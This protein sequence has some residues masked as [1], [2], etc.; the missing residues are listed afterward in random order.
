MEHGAWQACTHA[1]ITHSCPNTQAAVADR[2]APAPV[3]HAG[4]STTRTTGQDLQTETVQT[5][6]AGSTSFYRSDCMDGLLSEPDRYTLWFGLLP[7]GPPVRSGPNN[8]ATSTSISGATRAPP[9]ATLTMSKRCGA[10][11]KHGASVMGG[12]EKHRVRRA[13]EEGRSSG[14]SEARCANR[15][16]TRGQALPL[17]LC[18]IE[19][20]DYLRLCLDPEAKSLVVS[21]RT[22]GC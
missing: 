14:Q 16:D 11:L 22:F 17:I 4:R 1:H 8:N 21:H 5:E 2:Q 7:V 3:A 10:R 18:L 9:P 13:V 12:S 6:L 15:T 19:E 20:I